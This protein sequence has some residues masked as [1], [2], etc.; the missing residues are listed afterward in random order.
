LYMC[1]YIYIYI[2]IYKFSLS[3]SRLLSRSQSTQHPIGMIVK[4]ERLKYIQS[5]NKKPTVDLSC[6]SLRRK[7]VPLSEIDRFLPH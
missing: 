3:R 6:S 4:T 7:T 1:T 5:R 2:Y